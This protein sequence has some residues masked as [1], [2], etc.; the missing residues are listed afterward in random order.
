MVVSALGDARDEGNPVA[1][2]AS[3]MA[4]GVAATLVAPDM[5]RPTVTDNELG[6]VVFFWKGARREIQIELDSDTSWFV[7]IKRDGDVT[8]TDEGF[9]SVPMNEVNSALREWATERRG[10]LNPSYSRA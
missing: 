9:G 10:R 2:T 4:Y 8:F 3:Q 1:R 6:G 5:L 7:R